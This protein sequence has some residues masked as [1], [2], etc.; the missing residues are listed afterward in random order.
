MLCFAG[1]NDAGQLGDNSNDGS[2]VPVAVSGG[3]TWAYIA[4]GGG[5][6]NGAHTWW[7]RADFMMHDG[8]LS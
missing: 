7:V 6:E 3:G 2:A 8:F 5:D 1:N 4:A